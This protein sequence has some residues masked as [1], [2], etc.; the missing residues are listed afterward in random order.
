MKATERLLIGGEWTESAKHDSFESIDPSSG[1]VLAEVSRAGP[2]D[3]DAAVNAARAAFDDATWRRVPPADR[4]RIMLGIAAR[5]R[6]SAGELA[7]LES[8]DTGKPISQARFDIAASA[9]YFEFYG[10][11][12]DK[13]LGSTIPLGRG[14]LDYTVREPIGVSAQIIPWNSP[15][16]VFSRGVAPALA[17]GCAIVVKPSVEAPLSSLRLGAIAIECG[18]PPGVVNVVPGSGAEAGAA[19]ASHPEVDQITFTG[20]VET[21][22]AIAKAAAANV[23]PVTMELGG[24][25]P[26]IV[27]ADA[28]LDV[29]TQAIMKSITQNAGQIC[30]AGSRVLVNREIEGEVVTRLTQLAQRVRVGRGSDDPDMGPLI[31]RSQRERV[32]AY[33]QVGRDE[34]AKIAWGGGRP[35]EEEFA[36]GFFI[37]PTIFSDVAN[38]MRIG[39]EEIF[40]P[41]LSV[42]G[43]QGA[44]E[45]LTLANQSQYG[46]VAGVWTS[47]VNTAMTMADGL[48][49]GQ[50]FVNTFGAGTGVELP[51]GGFKKSGY[52]RE[53]GLEALAS[54]TQ[55]KNVC[56]KFS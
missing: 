1:E 28:D 19:L 30:S 55:L 51:F 23:V 45:A 37:E 20:S 14:F 6:E 38:E 31:S 17:A 42:V 3:I 33:I 22:I 35:K 21:G 41:V 13:I 53:K 11:A 49:T 43:F 56:I 46:L 9:R 7:D 16:H 15:A 4:G 10:G 18:V 2:A 39:Q 48:R 40:G 54:Y 27:F 52:G 32:E 47:D 25:S 36:H 24:K 44:T 5:I 26:Q 12:A 8:R 29:A 50:V 34:G